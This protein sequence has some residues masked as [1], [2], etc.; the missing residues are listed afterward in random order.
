MR[1]TKKQLVEMTEKWLNRNSDAYKALRRAARRL[2][3]RNKH[4]PVKFLVEVMRYSGYLGQDTMHRV[5]DMMDGVRFEGRDYSIPNEVTAGIA[6]KLKDD[7]IDVVV[8]KSKFDEPDEEFEQ[9]A[10]FGEE[11]G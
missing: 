8:R 4:V 7:G 3:E 2:Q 11:D 10:L 1:K 9:L 5:V 6:R